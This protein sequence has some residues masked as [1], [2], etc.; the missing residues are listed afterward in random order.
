[1]HGWVAKLQDRLKVIHYRAMVKGVEVARKRLQKANVN[2]SK[3]EL[4]EGSLVLLRVPGL[5]SNLEASWEGP[6]E[7]VKRL[8]KVNY[9]VRKKGSSRE[10]KVVHISNTKVFTEREKEV[11]HVTVAEED[12]EMRR[13]YGKSDRLSEEKCEGY[14]EKE[15]EALVEKNKPFFSE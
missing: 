3:R 14:D 13:V 11:Y 9:R 7:V 8:N 2:R 1:M 6:Y 12:N 5:V 10:G 15:L 4:S